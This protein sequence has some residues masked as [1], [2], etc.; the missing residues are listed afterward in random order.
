MLA[1]F[2]MGDTPQ[3]ESTA[4]MLRH[5]GYDEIMVCGPQVREELAHIGCDTIISVSRM[6]DLGYDKH[7]KD[8][9]EARIKDMD[10]CDLFVE[11]KVRNVE[12]IWERWPHL[13]DKVAWWRVNGAQPEICPVG[14]DE[15][16]L[17]CPIITAC[18]WYGTKRYTRVS[19]HSLPSVQPQ[20]NLEHLKN[21][22]ITLEEL[23]A[24]SDTAKTG[25]NEM[26]YTF[27]PPYPRSLEYDK[28]DRT[29]LKEFKSPFCVCHSVYA[30]GFNDAIDP[31]IKFDVKFYGNNSPHGQ[32]Q[33]SDVPNICRDAL[34]LVHMK[35]VDCPGWALYEALLSGTPVI[36]ARQL[37]SR[38]LAY[39]L[40]EDQE[41]CLEFGVPASLEYGRGDTNIPKCIDDIDKALDQLM[42]PEENYRI[43]QAGKERLNTLMWNE[44]RDGDSFKRFMGRWF[45]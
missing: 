18:L 34:G 6:V 17:I 24:F 9:T 2:N 5:A 31:C 33:H 25:F 26:A 15:V 11:I 14:G 42:D 41:T 27:W 35:S 36:T 19:P 23:K 37:N 29:G 30:W 40:L 4:Q 10:R 38:M 1:I 45:G 28:I 8:I 13:K 32:V 7:T 22:P 44:E 20:S 43:G 16:N 21:N 3:I 39:D 12:K